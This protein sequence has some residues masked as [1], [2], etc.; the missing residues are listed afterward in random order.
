MEKYR[1]FS[2]TR[3]VLNQNDQGE[4]PIKA[5]CFAILVTNIGG[6]GAATAFIEG[7]PINAALVAGANGESWSIGGIA[8]T[9]IGKSTLEVHFNGA[10][11]SVFVQQAFYTDA[12]K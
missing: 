2:W 5:G 8:G 9:I 3:Q 1:P 4:I 10:N 7:Y 11:G 12:D 6:V